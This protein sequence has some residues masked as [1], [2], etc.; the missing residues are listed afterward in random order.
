MRALTHRAVDARAGVPAGTTSAY[1]RTRQALIEAVVRRLA[2][3]DRADLATHDL[4][5][6]PPPAA[7][8]QGRDGGRTAEPAPGGRLGCVPCCGRSPAAEPGRG[9]ATVDRSR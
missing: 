2:D 6:E 9:Q 8:G 3:L 7:T 1:L 5:T 4:P